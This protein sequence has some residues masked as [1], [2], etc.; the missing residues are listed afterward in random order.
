MVDQLGVLVYLFTFDSTSVLK[1]WTPKLGVRT[2]THNQIGYVQTRHLA[3][4]AVLPALMKFFKF[5]LFCFTGTGRIGKGGWGM[6]CGA[7]GSVLYGSLWLH[8]GRHTQSQL[9]A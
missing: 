7:P 2:E 3:H 9:H 5:L 1:V 8:A 4:S 6:P